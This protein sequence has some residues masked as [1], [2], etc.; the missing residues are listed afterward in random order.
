MFQCLE[1]EITD[2]EKKMNVLGDNYNEINE[3]YIKKDK[4]EKELEEAMEGLTIYN[5]QIQEN[6]EIST[7]NYKSSSEI[8]EAIDQQSESLLTLVNLALELNELS[9][10]L[11]DIINNFKL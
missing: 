7:N 5:S 1:E 2:M 10:T 9:D 4:L 11:N 8:S 6:N 3:L